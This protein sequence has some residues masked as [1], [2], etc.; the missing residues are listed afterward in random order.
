MGAA[1]KGQGRAMY[2]MGLDYNSESIEKAK[3]L[4]DKAITIDLNNST[5]VEEILNDQKFDCIICAD[6]LEH[7]VDPL[8]LIRELYKHLNTEGRIIIS[9]PNMNHWSIFFHLLI[10]KYPR[11]NRGIYDKTHLQFYLLHNLPEL[12]VYDL[13]FSLLDRNFRIFDQKQG[14]W[15]KTFMRIFKYI[16]WF[17][18]FVTY[19][20]IFELTKPE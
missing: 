20:F 19:Q 8:G 15:D 4:L 18:N 5:K 3:L 11:R 16:P 2:V 1:L 9:L 14:N 7:L 12:A 10:N 13:K 17:R 6:V